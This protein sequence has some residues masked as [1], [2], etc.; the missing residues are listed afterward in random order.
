ME[1]EMTVPVTASVFEKI[2]TA[3][4]L[5]QIAVEIS[6]IILALVLI[7]ITIMMVLSIL[8]IRKEIISL[9]YRI[10]YIARM[11]KREIEEAAFET[12]PAK[13]KGAEEKETY[14]EEWKF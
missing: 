8:R 14:K 12:Q 1:T 3:T 7:L 2:A 10:G 11:L 6:F 4:G 5:P 13:R 9:N